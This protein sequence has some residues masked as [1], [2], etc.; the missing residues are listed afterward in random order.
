MLRFKRAILGVAVTML[1]LAGATGKS[2]SDEPG[3]FSNHL[4]GGSVGLPLGV[5]LPP[6]V[7]S[8]L[9]NLWLPEMP[10]P[11][12][13]GNQGTGHI[14]AIVGGV[15]LVWSTGWNVFGASYTMSAL[16]GMIFAGIYSNTTNS[17]A[18]VR[19]IS[20]VS[21]PGSTA[22]I[23]TDLGNTTLTPISLSWNLGQGW[24][25]STNFSFMVPD[26][27]RSIGSLSPIPDYWTFEP[28]VG[29]SYI[30]ESW[31]LSGNFFYDFNTASKGH[32]CGG[33]TFAGPVSPFDGWENGEKVYVDLTAL[34]KVGKWQFG[35]IAWLDAETTSDEPGSGFNCTTSARIGV[36]CGH[37]LD[38]AAGGLVGYDFGPIKAQ[39]WATYDVL[40]R[41]CIVCI[42]SFQVGSRLSFALWA[43]DRTALITKN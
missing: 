39:V 42:N 37:F 28:S 6:G 12:S 36:A 24:F 11:R 25:V 14:A 7:Y 26:G 19:V 10:A 35:P 34:Y 1:V 33:T 2:F 21:A 13:T 17:N 16:Q 32:C 8:G 18:S 4:F 5:A 29:I 27:T 38:A 9:Q 23:T 15:P 22:I 30:S 20:G 40:A 41:D 3:T 43:P 31:L